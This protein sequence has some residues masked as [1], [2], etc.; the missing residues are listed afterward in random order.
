MAL[1]KLNS[2]S[3]ALLSVPLLSEARLVARRDQPFAT[4]ITLLTEFSFPPLLSI[5]D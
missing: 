2:V 4:V 5:R 3:Q 1:G